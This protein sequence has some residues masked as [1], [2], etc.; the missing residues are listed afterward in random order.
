MSNASLKQNAS[1]QNGN[2]QNQPNMAADKNIPGEM[3]V[4]GQTAGSVDRAVNELLVEMTFDMFC[5]TAQREAFTAENLEM[6]IERG[7]KIN[8][9]TTK[10]WTI[11]MFAAQYGESDTGELLIAHGAD[12]NLGARNNQ[13]PIHVAA[14]NGKA[15]F[16]KVLCLNGSE[17]NVQDETGLTPIA[18][19]SMYEFVDVVRILK[20]HGA[21]PEISD[22]YGQNA[23]SLARDYSYKEIIEILE[24]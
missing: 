1:P 9:A 17:L 16:V 13:M 10:G 19:A 15:E 2:A 7:F 3:A 6:F 24:S 11:L 8:Q 23:L 21:D 4:N 18:Y 12:V 22:S 5:D 20:E 14:F